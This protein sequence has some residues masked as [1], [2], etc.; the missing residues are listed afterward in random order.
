MNVPDVLLLLSGYLAGSLPMGLWI[1]RARGVDLREH[2]SRNIGA[3]NAGRVL[4]R[5]WFYAVF[6]LDFA[7]A[8]APA[9]VARRC[10]SGALEPATF[11]LLV[12]VAAILGHVFPLFLR[13]KGG[14]GVATAAG[15]FV[16]AAP[17]A[18][19]AAWAAWL[20]VFL[21]TRY[22]SLASLVAAL[23]LPLACFALPAVPPPVGAD[24]ARPVQVAALL[25]GLL[26][27]VRHRANIGRR[28][29]GEESRAG[30][31]KS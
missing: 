19:A 21:A 6:A 13:F 12:G 3:T 18:T 7:K 17:M 2:G 4:G 10:G 9:L 16:A 23:V 14:K 15:V 1:G 29:R 11:A 20:L 27:I 8:L 24:V 30:R 31:P 28:V 5:K 26:I 25:V 22:V